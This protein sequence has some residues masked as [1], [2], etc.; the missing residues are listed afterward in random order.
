MSER[1]KGRIE[2]SG[3]IVG[4][5]GSGHSRRALEWPMKEAAVRRVLILLAQSEAVADGPA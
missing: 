2:V 5:D 4:V 1:K 3:I